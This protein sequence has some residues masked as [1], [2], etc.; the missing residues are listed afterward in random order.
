V[1]EQYLELDLVVVVVGQLPT[2]AYKVAVVQ[3]DLVALL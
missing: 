3:K 2:L 1:V